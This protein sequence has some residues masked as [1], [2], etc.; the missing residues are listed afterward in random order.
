[1]RAVA[2]PHVG[3]DRGHYGRSQKHQ[4]HSFGR[5]PS[6]F[7]THLT[8]VAAELVAQLHQIKRDLAASANRA[9]LDAIAW[10][11]L[12]RAGWRET[13]PLDITLCSPRSIPGR[14]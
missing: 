14:S 2:K 5:V 4:S 1:M 7:R 10:L 8:P 3:K 13:L 11:D 12:N 6:T 9:G